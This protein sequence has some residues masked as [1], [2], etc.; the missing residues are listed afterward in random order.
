MEL[1]QRGDSRV[2][3]IIWVNAPDPGKKYRL[4]RWVFLFRK[5]GAAVLRSSL[6]KDIYRLDEAEWAAVRGGDPSEPVVGELIRQGFLV[7]EKSNDLAQYFLVLAA[8]R[9]LTPRKNGAE[10]F[11]ILPTTGCNA[12]CVYCYQEGVAVKSMAA[13]TADRV[14]EYVCA[15][16]AP[17]KA[18]LHWFGGEPL[19]AAGVISRI[20]AALREKGVTFTSRVTT[21]GSL[22]TPAL[23]REAVG[24]WGLE[25]VQ[26]SMDGSKEDYVARKRYLLPEK[27]NY[28]AVMDNIR[29]LAEAGVTVTIRCN[30][31]RDN[32]QSVHAFLDE[33]KARFGETGKV[34]VVPALLLQEIRS[35]GR[36]AGAE[37][38]LDDL[39]DHAVRLGYTKR[40]DRLPDR[41]RFSQCMADSGGRNVII[42]PEGGL[43]ACD[44]YVGG[45]P[46]GN[47]FDDTPPAW[48][49]ASTEP[50]EECVNCC[51]LPDCTA[52]FKKICPFCPPNCRERSR[53][54]VERLLDKLLNGQ[55]DPASAEE[56]E[57]PC[58]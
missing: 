7:E 48:P 33:C 37:A 52:T 58:E 31:D 46:L 20:C 3:K 42:D 55:Q 54:N 51:F 26:I 50:E 29:Q 22:F 40:R 10:I 43:H 27:H 35:P 9:S 32:L 5:D 47:I 16:K 14:A 12:R 6:S 44:Y 2:K 8:L 45:E 38:E 4:S 11:T 41:F 23:I 36:H 13:D 24:L 18:E 15:H 49:T 39:A 53:K 25:K 30:F 17:G 56:E 19:C 21:N 57:P 28:D 1:L 34:R